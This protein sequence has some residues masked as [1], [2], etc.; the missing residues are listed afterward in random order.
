MARI[1]LKTETKLMKTLRRY[2]RVQSREEIVET[3]EGFGCLDAKVESHA[4][5]IRMARLVRAIKEIA[6]KKEQVS[7]C[8]LV[9]KLAEEVESASPGVF[10]SASHLA[11]GRGHHRSLDELGRAGD[12]ISLDD[13]DGEEA[14]HEWRRD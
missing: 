13:I 7:I 10:D 14:Y 9:M 2:Q 8:N 1:S 12:V 11:N 5:W 3:A 4:K 6:E